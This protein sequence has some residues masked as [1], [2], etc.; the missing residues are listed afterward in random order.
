MPGPS[1]RPAPRVKPP[2]RG[3]G[4]Y[5]TVPGQEPDEVTTAKPPEDDSTAEPDL[6][7]IG[8]NHMPEDL[9]RLEREDAPEPEG[10][11]D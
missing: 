1:P 8:D 10:T 3:Y 2:V 11:S 5:M 4:S 9:R 6:G 7:A